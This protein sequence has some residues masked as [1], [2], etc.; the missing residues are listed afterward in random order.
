VLIESLYVLFGKIIN[1]Y[2]HLLMLTPY[3]SAGADKLSAI[4]KLSASYQHLSASYQ[5]RS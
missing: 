3:A 5:Q 2:Q 1:I 4:S